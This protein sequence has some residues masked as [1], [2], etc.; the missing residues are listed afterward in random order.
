MSGE[1]HLD[2]R[3]K[4]DSCSM[5]LAGVGVVVATLVALLGR[6]GK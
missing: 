1:R 4:V 3:K 2:G 5:R 6:K